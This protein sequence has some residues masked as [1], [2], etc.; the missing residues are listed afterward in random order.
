MPDKSFYFQYLNL[1]VLLAQVFFR[2]IPSIWIVFVI[3]LWEGLM[4]GCAYVNTFYRISTEV[5]SQCVHL[6][7]CIIMLFN[8]H[9]TIF[10]FP[11]VLLVL[12]WLSVLSYVI[13][14]SKKKGASFP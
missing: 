6:N 1:F 3:I 11:V 9:I 10:M 4:G 5:S 12:F 14:R 2:F 13:F 7:V 8:H